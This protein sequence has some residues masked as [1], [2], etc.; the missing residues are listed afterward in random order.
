VHRSR[1]SRQFFLPWVAKWHRLLIF[2]VN[3]G[4]KLHRN[5]NSHCFIGPFIAMS[6]LSIHNAVQIG[7]IYRWWSSAPRETLTT[8]NP[9]SLGG[10]GLGRREKVVVVLVWWAI[11]KLPYSDANFTFTRYTLLSKTKLC[12]PSDGGVNNHACNRHNVPQR[13]TV[14]YCSSVSKFGLI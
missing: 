10:W 12:G 14:R 1:P 5:H 8:R 11:C 2:R 3:G 6:P 9:H 4:G 13:S 7:G